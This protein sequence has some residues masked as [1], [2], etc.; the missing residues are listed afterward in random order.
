M[1]MNILFSLVPKDLDGQA[2]IIAL[3]PIQKG[4]EVIFDNL[5]FF[6]CFNVEHKYFVST[7]PDHYFIYRRGPSGWGETGIACRLWLQM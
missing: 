1:I 7:F 4:E 5:I 3:Q 2:T 6:A